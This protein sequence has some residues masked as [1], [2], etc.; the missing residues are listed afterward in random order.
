MLSARYN[1]VLKNWH[2]ITEKDSLYRESSPSYIY[3]PQERQTEIINSEHVIFRLPIKEVKEVPGGNLVRCF[4]FNIVNG[5]SGKHTTI[6]SIDHFMRH[7]L[8]SKYSIVE[9]DHR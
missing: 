2:C 8:S 1:C 9:F 7:I 3:T 5:F 6:E 4:D